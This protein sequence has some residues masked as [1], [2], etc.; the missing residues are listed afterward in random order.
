MQKEKRYQ[1]KYHQRRSNIDG[2]LIILSCLQLQ[3]QLLRRW[4]K[5][6]LRSNHGFHLGPIEIK[7]IKW[8]N[9]LKQLTEER[10]SK[11]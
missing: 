11:S 7:Q 4:N 6:I 3:L 10:L 1:A 2:K 5:R 8:K 9:R